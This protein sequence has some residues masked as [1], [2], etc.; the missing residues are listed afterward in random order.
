MEIPRGQ[1]G[2]TQRLD[3]LGEKQRNVDGLFRAKPTEDTSK[4]WLVVGLEHEFYDFPY[5]GNVIIPADFHIF[6]RG[7]STTNQLMFKGCVLAHPKL[8]WTI[9][10]SQHKPTIFAENDGTQSQVFCIGQENGWVVST[11]GFEDIYT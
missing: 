8:T 5:I 10:G 11:D 7:G 2:G 9:C 4:Y 1:Q 3:P 6:Q